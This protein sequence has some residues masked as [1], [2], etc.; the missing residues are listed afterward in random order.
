MRNTN[1]RLISEYNLIGPSPFISLS[2]LHSTHN[3]VHTPPYLALPSHSMFYPSTSEDCA[4]ETHNN[5]REIL[6]IYK[7][8]D[9]LSTIVPSEALHNCG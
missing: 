1:G 3:I 7:W 4:L 2:T 6:H 9:F 5:M 8:V